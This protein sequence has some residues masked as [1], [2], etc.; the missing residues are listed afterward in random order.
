VSG[1]PFD[2][3]TSRIQRAGPGAGVKAERRARDNG[4]TFERFTDRARQVL[5]L[6][7]KEARQLNHSF[8]GT[9]HLLLGLLAE[10]DGVAAQA[11][12]RLGL[13]LEDARDR[14]E[15]IVG[16]HATSP[17]GS[18]PFTP[19]A[20]RA[21]ELSLREALQ[22]QHNYIGTEHLL[23]GLIREGE[24]VAAQVMVGLGADLSRVR[25]TVEQLLTGTNQPASSQ[26][27]RG[28]VLDFAVQA[29]RQRATARR[30]VVG[31]SRTRLECGFCGR[32]TWELAHYLSNGQVAICS[33]CVR[34]AGVAVSEVSPSQHE[35]FLPPRVFGSVPDDGAVEAVA[36]ALNT[37]F[38]GDLGSSALETTVQDFDEL[39]PFLAAAASRESP[40]A[41]TTVVLDRVRFIDAM[42]AT[43]EFRRLF[44]RTSAELEGLM[45]C[46]DGRWLV[47]RDT[48]AALLGAAGV[49]VP[50]PIDS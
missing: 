30:R 5:V 10:G 13:T 14:V 48:M 37:T 17:T 43:V 4:D 31:D 11:L 42:H 49:A 29:P 24:G 45:V 38:G 15:T 18:P 35:V 32:D 33:E 19:R 12:A 3:S 40:L 23:L 20:K 1:S 26:R 28:G 47:S 27:Q 22:R 7:Q 9:E 2:P 44:N 36:A 41:S 16:A 21:L 6:A 8:V 25:A 50:P 34:A 39:Q 46:L